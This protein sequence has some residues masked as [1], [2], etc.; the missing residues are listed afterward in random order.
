VKHLT[1]TPQSPLR[2]VFAVNMRRIRREQH[3]SQGELGS[4]LGGP[5]TY[6][7]IG[8]LERGIYAPTLDMVE[9]IAAALGVTATGL[10]TPPAPDGES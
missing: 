5:A 3:L 2:D 7:H 10:L 8:R 9:R 6:S 1:L 4:R